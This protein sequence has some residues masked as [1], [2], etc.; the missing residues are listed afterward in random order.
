MIVWLN[1]Y[2]DEFF[3]V[4]LDFINILL[5]SLVN[6][7]NFKLVNDDDFDDTLVVIEISLGI[8]GVFRGKKEELLKNN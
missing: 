1:L 5:R 8:Y 4:N 2:L 7:F 3:I 6:L